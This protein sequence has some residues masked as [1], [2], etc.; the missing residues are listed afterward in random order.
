M[1]KNKPQWS[2]IKKNLK[3]QGYK[4]FWLRRRPSWTVNG[5]LRAAAF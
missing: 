2:L 4:I 3:Q 1:P 5:I